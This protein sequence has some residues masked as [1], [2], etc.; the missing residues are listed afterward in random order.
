MIVAKVNANSNASSKRLEDIRPNEW[1]IIHDYILLMR[2]IAVSL[3][4][5]QRDHSTAGAILPCLY[6]INR[7]LQQVRLE[8]EKSLNHGIQ[9]AGRK[10]KQALL[11]SFTKRFEKTM[12]ISNENKELIVS[13]ICHPA[14]KLDWVEPEDFSTAQ[15]IF[16]D[17]AESFFET[18]HTNIQIDSDNH[19][20][21][22]YFLVNQRSGRRMS[23]DTL[24]GEIQQYLTNE[25]IE[26]TMLSLYKTIRKM[27]FRFYT[28]IS[29][30]AP[31]ERSFS[32]AQ[33][34]FVPRRN[35]LSDQNFEYSLFL[36]INKSL[37][38]QK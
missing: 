6:F 17:E 27:F 7:E 21:R 15:Y 36:K 2:P 1:T 31:I 29:S 5:M 10:M 26:F 33:L 13:S 20:T 3:D 34:I 4:R 14:F 28:S 23:T 16:E 38:E 35:R 24:A 19:L 37:L 18:D 30:S 11:T 25:N 8:S 12:N 22:D 32:K 9:I